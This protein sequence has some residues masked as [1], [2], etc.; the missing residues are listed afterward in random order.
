MIDRQNY[1]FTIG[2]VQTNLNNRNIRIEN[3]EL[4]FRKILS[5]ILHHESESL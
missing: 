1:V 2:S 3:R 5:N 4:C